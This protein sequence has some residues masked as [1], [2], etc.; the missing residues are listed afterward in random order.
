LLRLAPGGVGGCCENGSEVV[1]RGDPEREG[2][3]EGRSADERGR[4]CR[5]GAVTA[6]CGRCNDELFGGADIGGYPADDAL[7]FGWTDATSS[8]ESGPSSS[9]GLRAISCPATGASA[10][11][12][13]SASTRALDSPPSSLGRRPCV[14]AQSPTRSISPAIPG[15]L[16]SITPIP[17]NAGGMCGLTRIFGLIAASTVRKDG[18]SKLP[19]VE[20]PRR[21]ALELG[22]EWGK[23]R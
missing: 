23:D 9:L 14:T 16:A 6:G 12:S 17:T 20:P 15:A 22:G 2:M 8:S 7:V 10:P 19:K 18:L 5:L 13:F 3:P 1:C 21:A 11:P 4:A